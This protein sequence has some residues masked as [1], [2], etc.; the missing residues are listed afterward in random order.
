MFVSQRIRK[1]EL[2]RDISESEDVNKFPSTK[3]KPDF[4]RQERQKE[5]KGKQF[6]AHSDKISGKVT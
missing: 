4:K 6:K 5:A 1:Q 3:R 2:R